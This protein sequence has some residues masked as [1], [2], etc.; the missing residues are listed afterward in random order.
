MH[1]RDGGETCCGFHCI[2]LPETLRH[3][4]RDHEVLSSSGRAGEKDAVAS[5]PR[6]L[7]KHQS[8]GKS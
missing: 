8:T 3:Q 2:L 5:L 6:P 4:Y 1:C 7:G